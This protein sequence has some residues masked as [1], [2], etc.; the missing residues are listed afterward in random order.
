MKNEDWERVHLT[1]S[2]YLK[3]K[4]WEEEE[5]FYEIERNKRLPAIIKIVIPRFKKDE[6]TINII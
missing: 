3:E 6:R 1:D 5:H 2:M 4:E